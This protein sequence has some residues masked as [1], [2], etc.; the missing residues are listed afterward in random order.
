[1]RIGII[2]DSHGRQQT[3][4]KALDQLRARGIDFVVHCGDIDDADTVGLFRNFHAHF[5]FGNCDSDRQGIRRAIEEIGGVLH[6]RFGHLELEGRKIAWTHSDDARLFRDL[7]LSGHYDFLF[8]GHT[9]HA[10]QHRTGPTTVV[11]PGALQRAK[12]KTFVILDLETG[13]LDSVLVE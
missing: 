2:S 3:V 7:E 12:P 10:E 13:E 5:V 9:H 1:M 6:D 4:V 8:Y 11:N